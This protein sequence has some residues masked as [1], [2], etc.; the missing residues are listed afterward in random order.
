MI[1]EYEELRKVSSKTY[2]KFVQDLT[3]FQIPS[4]QYES[5][6]NKF[7]RLISN[8]IIKD[9]T[10][11]SLQKV[12]RIMSLTVVMKKSMNDYLDH[13]MEMKPFWGIPP[14]LGDTFHKETYHKFSDWVAQWY[15][16]HKELT[17]I[18]LTGVI[19]TKAF[20]ESDL[21]R[22][23]KI[24]LN[25]LWH[26]WLSVMTTT[27]N[28]PLE[29]S[30]RLTLFKFK[31]LSVAWGILYLMRNIISTFRLVTSRYRLVRP[32]PGMSGLN[33]P[34]KVSHSFS[35]TM[36]SFNWLSLVTFILGEWIFVGLLSSIMWVAFVTLLYFFSE[37]NMKDFPLFL[38][39]VDWFS[40][41]LI[42]VS[43][44]INSFLFPCSSIEPSFWGWLYSLYSFIWYQTI[45]TSSWLTLAMI[46]E[47]DSVASV[48]T[49]VAF[50]PGL[51]SYLAFMAGCFDYF[52]IQAFK[53]FFFALWDF[54][55]PEWFDKLL[56]T[57][58][59]D[60]SMWAITSVYQDVN[61]AVYHFLSWT[62]EVRTETVT[63]TVLDGIA[64]EP[65]TIVEITTEKFSG[66]NEYLNFV[67]AN[68]P[69][70]YYSIRTI[71]ISSLLA[72]SV[73]SLSVATQTVVNLVC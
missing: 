12:Q 52:V 4:I 63:Q 54:M 18:Q 8:E 58:V 66:F 24:R 11:N 65:T 14:F 41:H 26:R 69:L 2:W 47:M 28:E 39:L 30:G 5:E 72:A 60:I 40:P 33:L 7:K 59:V 50:E 43:K 70:T 44:W 32:V 31:H 16:L 1:G 51:S 23:D 36:K 35:R 42:T 62:H 29:Q 57:R 27:S 21:R 68:A 10:D 46:H 73:W 53:E 19:P 20:T 9:S 3:L 34:I 38:L 56:M 13:L 25:K 48:W 17:D 49:S 15:S 64:Q 22:G 6:N 45:I 61:T 55:N 71:A 67:R 37:N